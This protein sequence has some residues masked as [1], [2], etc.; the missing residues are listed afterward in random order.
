MKVLVYSRYR[1]GRVRVSRKWD[2]DGNALESYRDFVPLSP[3]SPIGKC[4]MAPEEAA[5]VVESKESR[6]QEASG[7][8]I[9]WYP[10]GFPLPIPNDQDG[11]FYPAA[12]DTNFHVADTRQTAAGEAVLAE[13]EAAMRAAAEAEENA[14][15]DDLHVEEKTE[16]KSAARKAR[17][18]GGAA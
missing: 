9:Y 14:P 6:Q 11:A 3:K 18:A 5:F 8:P 13:R 7:E 12:N 10:S 1:E 15:G 4:Y 17:S 2:K 16:S